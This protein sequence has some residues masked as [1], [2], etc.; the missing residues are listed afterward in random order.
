MTVTTTSGAARQLRSLPGEDAARVLD[1]VATCPSEGAVPIHGGM[2]R[3]T[4]ETSLGPLV[5]LFTE[6]GGRRVLL[7]ARLANPP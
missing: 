3:L 5:L 2:Y 7:S 4:V 1:A 6:D